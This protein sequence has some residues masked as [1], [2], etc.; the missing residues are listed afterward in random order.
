MFPRFLDFF[1]FFKFKNV[2]EK[3]AWLTMNADSEPD[4]ILAM[5]VSCLSVAKSPSSILATTSVCHL[6]QD[7]SNLA[8]EVVFNSSDADG[9]FFSSSSRLRSGSVPISECSLSRVLACSTLPCVT[10][11]FHQASQLIPNRHLLKW[12]L[13]R[14]GFIFFVDSWIL[15]SGT[16]SWGHI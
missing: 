7:I 14:V 11:G 8:T 4:R 9:I 15:H 16:D 12:P 5:C 10:E 1:F 13:G 2:V 3:K 6:R